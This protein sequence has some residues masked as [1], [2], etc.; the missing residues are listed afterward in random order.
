MEIQYSDREYI[1]DNWKKEISDAEV[2]MKQVG[3]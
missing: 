1:W 3:N 2:S